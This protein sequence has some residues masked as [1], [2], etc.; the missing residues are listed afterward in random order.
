MYVILGLPDKILLIYICELNQH[1]S[2][3]FTNRTK[4]S[5]D[6]SETFKE[7]VI[8]IELIQ[9]IFAASTG[10]QI[11]NLNK[12]LSDLVEVKKPPKK[13]TQKGCLGHQIANKRL[14]S[15]PYINGKSLS[16]TFY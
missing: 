13:Q 9:A 12:G 14:T 3:M 5:L 15:E 8:N 1:F 4:H 11:V 16:S 10:A 6:I 7:F 2:S